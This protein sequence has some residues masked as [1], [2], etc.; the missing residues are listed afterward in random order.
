MFPY[1]DRHQVYDW[2]VPLRERLRMHYTPHLSRHAMATELRGMGMD[3]K[4]VAERGLWRDERSVDR[5]DHHRVGAVPGH[6]V[7]DLLAKKRG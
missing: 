5:Y 4:D 6:G 2:L 3:R 1:N 7:S